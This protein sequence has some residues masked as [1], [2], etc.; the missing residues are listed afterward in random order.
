MKALDQTK[1]FSGWQFA[2]FRIVFG[3]YLALHFLQLIPYGAELFGGSGLIPDVALNPTAGLFP[4]PFGLPLSDGVIALILV[5]LVVASLM[6]TVGVGR[7]WVALLLWFGW[8]ALF[9]RN[10]LIANPS[11]PYV[12]LLLLLCALVPKG[13]PLSFGGKSRDWAMPGWIWRC[14]W[15]LMAVGY[16]F[17]GWTKL[18]SPS[19]I[20]GTAMK[21]L[22]E[23]PLARDAW[24]RDLMLMLPDAILAGLTWLTLLAELL[25][26]P[27]AM[28]R[29]SRP[30]IWLLLVGMHLGIIVVVDFADLSLGML[31]I[32][33]F[34]FDSAWLPPRKGREKV[35]AYD[36]EC[37]M[38]SGFI[39]FLARED[40]GNRIRFTTLQGENGRRLEE[41]AGVER[42]STMVVSDGEEVLTRSAALISLLEALGGMWR[43]AAMGGR[44]LPASWFD[45]IYCMVARKRSRSKDHC[46]LPSPEVLE[47]ML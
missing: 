32:H 24:T 23:N 1:E 10:N 39:G 31:M 5:L 25:F 18:S 14:A 27:L 38:C 30:W 12:G 45:R 35:L 37:L 40:R 6:F 11:I 46:G 43:V 29:K 47:R 4:T 15:V 2:L 20:D 3:S 36:G 7:P 9:H 44:M 34:T 13:E 28:W 21:Y 17:S 8:S 41:K 33:L 19:W 16:S 26:L 42:L 22:L